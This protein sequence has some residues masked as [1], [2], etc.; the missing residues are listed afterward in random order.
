MNQTIKRYEKRF[1][2]EKEETSKIYQERIS[3]IQQEKVNVEKKYEQKRKAL[4][5]LEK[6]IQ[7]IQS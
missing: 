6:Q 3:R 7:Q 2:R 1:K 4:K 5:D